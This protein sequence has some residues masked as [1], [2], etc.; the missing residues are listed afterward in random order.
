[1][2]IFCCRISLPYLYPGLPRNLHLNYLLSRDSAEN[3]LKAYTDTIYIAV[4]KEDLYIT[5]ELNLIS[6]IQNEKKS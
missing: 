2:F 6:S 3:L 4:W 1:M 5:G